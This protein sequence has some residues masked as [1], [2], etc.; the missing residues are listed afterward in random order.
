MPK[1]C[2]PSN[3]PEINL[4]PPD[5]IG[6]LPVVPG[7][8]DNLLPKDAWQRP[9]R[10]EFG[11]WSEPSPIPAYS[12]VVQLIWDD[13]DA[14]PVAQKSY[15]GSNPPALPPDL[16]LEVPASKLDEGIHT[17]RYRLLP[18]NLSTPQN[19]A[20][21]NITIDKIPP[22]LARPSGL[23]FPAQVL[24]PNTLTARYLEQ[25]NDEVKVGLPVYTSPRPWDRITWYWGE[26]PNTQEQGGV[27]ELDDKNYSEPLFITIA[28]QLIRDRRDGFRY[29]WYQVQDRA[30]NES[31]RSDVVELDVAATPIPRTLPWPTVEKASGV[32]EQQ[33]LDPLLATTGAVVETPEDAVIYPGE[34]VWVQWGEPGTLGARRIEQPI[35][36]G[37]RRY[38]VDMQAVAAHIGRTL[39]VRY[40][41]IDEQ[42][43]EHFSI[44]RQ[45][46]VQTI[47]SNR[48]EAVRC[49]GLSGGNLRYSTVAAA[50]ARLTLAKWSLI[51]TDQWIM[52]TMTGVGTSG[53]LVFE[54]VRKRAITAQEVVAGIGFGSDIR[55]PK[56]FLNTLRRN[57][58]LTGK[59]Y[60]SF[61]GGQTWPPVAA[62]NFPL[63]QLTFVD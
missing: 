8:E 29:V 23:N 47:P 60:L 56:A 35:T 49:D 31:Y 2:A 26:T 9:L 30:G 48:F 41:V 25:N 17:L 13:D 45:L 15:E 4:P 62:P 28:G 39:S 1:H 38:Q 10:V 24:P 54:A 46:Q 50:G 18:W 20:S 58:P 37:Q 16:W 55:V 12:D 51:T 42:D 63:L 3:E 5:V 14:N 7:G 43:G 6:V 32:G 40:G 57:A 21:V 61:D 22:V 59:V 19:S 36:P 27:I 34:R 11:W 44:R 33:T 53:D 52:I